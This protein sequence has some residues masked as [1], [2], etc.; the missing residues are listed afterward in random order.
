MDS[1]FDN[2]NNCL[3]QCCSLVPKLGFVSKNYIWIKD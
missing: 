3:L 2:E 1:T